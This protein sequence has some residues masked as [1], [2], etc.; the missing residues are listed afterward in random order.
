MLEV[1]AEAALMANPAKSP[2]W[3]A[4]A[5]LSL[6]RRPFNDLLFEAHSIHRRH[7][8]PNRVQLSKLLNNKT[9]GCP[10]GLRL[11]QPV[12]ASCDRPCGLETGRRR[13]DR[14]R[15]VQG[16]RQWCDALL[17]GRRVAESEVRATWMPSW[18]SFVA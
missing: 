15:G 8:D 16:Q 4:E 1:R 14:R 18:K 6:Y 17:H 13:N 12:I 7:F 2:A 9:G 3:T 11:L 10:R 5:A